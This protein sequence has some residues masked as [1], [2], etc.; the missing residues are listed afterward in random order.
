MAKVIEIPVPEYNVKNKPNYI[1]IGK[2]VDKVLEKSFPDGRYILRAIGTQ[3]HPKL[4]MQKLVAIIIETGTD[5]YDNKRK[6]VSH[7]EFSGYDYDIQ[8]GKVKI[9]NSKLTEERGKYQTVFGD[10][11]FHF[12]EHA[13]LD[14]GYSV[15]IDLLLLYD[16]SKLARAKKFHSKARSVRSRLNQYLYKFKDRK[17]KKD[18]LLGIVKIL[19]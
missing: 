4:S 8:A 10:I 1:K 5:K 14:R 3:D 6:S 15:R 16:P 9:K 18:A 11:V 13:P 17:N 19:K 12:Y 2:K 7:E